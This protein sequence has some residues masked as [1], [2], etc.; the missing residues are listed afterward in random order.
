MLLNCHFRLG[1]SRYDRQH[2]NALLT[3]KPANVNRWKHCSGVEQPKQSMPSRISPAN[4][5]RSRPMPDF[6]NASAE[7]DRDVDTALAGLQSPRGTRPRYT[8]TGRA[9][10][11]C[12]QTPLMLIPRFAR[13][14]RVLHSLLFL[15]WCW[16]VCWFPELACWVTGWCYEP[17]D[18]I[19]L[20]AFTSLS[21]ADGRLLFETE[22]CSCYFGAHVQ[23]CSRIYWHSV[24][25][26]LLKITNQS[27]T[28]SA[29]VPYCSG[30]HRWQLGW[31]RR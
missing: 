27:V 22:Y 24:I 12:C 26:N 23:L 2:Y 7:A 4:V 3:L 25:F 14:S 5:G 17:C 6:E 30:D 19:C 16:S 31:R 29:A 10:F 11:G 8:P 9:Q 15:C 21:S 18:R 28:C 13:L 20:S 1:A